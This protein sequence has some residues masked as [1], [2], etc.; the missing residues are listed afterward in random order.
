MGLFGSIGKLIGGGKAKKA[1]RK[2]QA[3]QIEFLNKALDIE[4]QRYSEA[5]NRFAPIIDQGTAAFNQQADLTGVNGDDKL[6]GALEAL[7]NS[8][9]YKT[10]FDSGEEAVLQNASATGGLRGGNTER[11]LADF[12]A[13]TFAQALQQ[14]LANLGAI[15]SPGISAIG[16]LSGFGAQN[17]A[18][19][20][21]IFGQQGAATAGG[22][23][24]RGGI[25]QGMWGSAGGALD[26]LLSSIVPGSSTFGKILGAF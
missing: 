10:L 20:G 8:S 24:T 13:D 9:F 21:N 2:A 23:L 6:A 4:N 11:G 15:A 17:A 19:A 26:K 3:A 18:N 14:Q 22:I 12:G 7:K 1:S 5:Q 16:Q 25:T